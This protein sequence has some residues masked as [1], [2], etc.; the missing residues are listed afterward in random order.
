M[1][2]CE[3]CARQVQ[4]PLFCYLISDVG[5]PGACH[6]TYIGVSC[7]P[8]FRLRAHNREPHFRCNAKTTSRA[9]HWRLVMVIGPWHANGAKQFKQQWRDESRK[10]RSRIEMGVYKAA[11]MQ[12]I[13][14]YNDSEC[15][16]AHALG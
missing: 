12:K 1:P 2:H 13:V 10:L 11:L 5:S 4:H 14:Y 7:Q 6:A 15:S 3:L 8:W 9:G 16:V